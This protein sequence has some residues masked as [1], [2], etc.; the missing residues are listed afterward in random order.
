MP[1]DTP[2]LLLGHL[3]LL[4]YSMIMHISEIDADTANMKISELDQ[5]PEKEPY[6]YTILNI[7]SHNSTDFLSQ[8]DYFSPLFNLFLT[9]QGIKLT[10]QDTSLGFFSHLKFPLEKFSSLIYFADQIHEVVAIVPS[11]IPGSLS[12]HEIVADWPIVVL[13]DESYKDKYWGFPLNLLLTPELAHKECI[14]LKPLTNQMVRVTFFPTR[15]RLGP[16]L[17][18]S[19]LPLPLL[20]KLLI[21]TIINITGNSLEN[22]E[23]RK[24]RQDLLEQAE[25]LS[26]NDNLMSNHLNS[27]INYTFR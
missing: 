22:V 16:L 12:L 15:T 14:I 4:D 27:I 24:H 25:L 3:G 18:N 1:N 26:K 7:S 10:S 13:W 9:Q 11:L 8:N 2:R 17:Q 20:S 5:F 23:I 6:F 19:I 21:Y